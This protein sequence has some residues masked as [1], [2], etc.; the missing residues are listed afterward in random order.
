MGENDNGPGAGA[1]NRRQL[2]AGDLQSKILTWEQLKRRGINMIIGV[3]YLG[4]SETVAA[5]AVGE[6]D[7]GPG[8][9]ASWS[10]GRSW[11]SA[12]ENSYWEFAL[13]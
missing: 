4:V 8:A 1:K 6:D 12:A 7:N 5:H 3:L 11:G 10:W 2:D 9:G 13:R